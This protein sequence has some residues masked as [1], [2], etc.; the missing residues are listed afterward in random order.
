MWACAKHAV[1]TLRKRYLF[2][3]W[4][5][6]SLLFGIT[7]GTPNTQPSLLC[8]SRAPTLPIMWKSPIVNVASDSVRNY[9]AMYGLIFL[10]DPRDDGQLLRLSDGIGYLLLTAGCWLSSGFSSPLCDLAA[11]KRKARGAPASSCGKY[12]PYAI[13]SS[14]TDH[15]AFLAYV[16]KM[17]QKIDPALYSTCYIRD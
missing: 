15:P 2:L 7:V 12:I 4:S 9:R 11:Q 3:L 13:L 10:A 5:V 8:I 17:R 6:Q 14:V 16:D 1:P